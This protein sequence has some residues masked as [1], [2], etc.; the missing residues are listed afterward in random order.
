M[1]EAVINPFTPIWWKANISLTIIWLLVILISLLFKEKER[2]KIAKFLGFLFLFDLIFFYFAL[3]YMDGFDPAY[4]LPLQYCS[5]MQILGALALISRRQ[6]LYEFVLFF[7]LIGPLQALYTPGLPHADDYFFIEFYISHG[8]AILSPL[9]LTFS[10]KMRP[11]PFAWLKTLL[12]F[13]FIATLIYFFNQRV[14]GNYMFL[15]EKPPLDH[16]LLKFWEWPNYL[17]SWMF[18]LA[19]FSISIAFIFWIL[20]K[21]NSK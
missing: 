19:S 18:I 5:I 9:Y 15:V 2:I 17:I 7:S 4:S 10:L 8:G 14:G 11:R 13:S 12:C 16:P 1:Y 6:F 21:L 3:Y 20:R